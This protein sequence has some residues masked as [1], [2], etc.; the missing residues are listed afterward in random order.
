[1]KADLTFHNGAGTVTGAHFTLRTPE[2][3]VAVDCGLLQGEAF[4]DS[5][6]EEPFFYNPKELEALIITHAHLDHIGRIPFLVRE[7]FAGPIYSTPETRM[8]AEISLRDTV[9]ILGEEARKNRKDPLYIE[10]DVENTFQNWK[11]VEYHEEIQI[12]KGVS[13][14]LHNAGHILGSA[15]VE[16]R[17]GGKK[18]VFTGDLGNS[19]SPLLHDAEV[20]ADADYLIMESVYGDRLHES[21]EERHEILEDIVESTIQKGGVLMIPAFSIE[22]TQVLLSEINE[23]IESRKVPPVP[24]FLDSPMA[25]KVTDIYKKA[26]DHFNKEARQEIAS[27]DDIFSFPGLEFTLSADES[28]AIS[29]TPNPKIII[30]GSGMSNGGR[31]LH[32]ERRYLPDEN[33]TLLIVGFQAAGSLGRK[34]F[35][36]AKTVMIFNQEVPVR[37]RVLSLFGYSAHKDRDGLLEYVEAT[38]SHIKKVFLVMGEPKAAQ[39][40][41][42]RIKDYL[43]VNAVVPEKN[44]TVTLEL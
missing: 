38:G 42:Q 11:G 26:T 21:V 4:C 22:R 7:G 15:V 8:I 39:F 43:G 6:N 33:S 44:T 14:F 32:H 37:A 18:V 9:H 23:L 28:K 25:I 12:G 40:L 19:L 16:M 3:F 1:M 35:E 17:V 27:G 10:K 30:A 13:V 29:E 31:I 2:A 5:C 24:V 34:L 41:S 36:G 20:V